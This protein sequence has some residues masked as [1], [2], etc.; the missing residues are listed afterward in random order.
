MIDLDRLRVFSEV[1]R[2]G[3]VTAAAKALHVT[4]SAVSQSLAKLEDQLGVPLFV[5]RH[6]R[7]VPTAAAATLDEIVAPFL[8]RLEHGLE[9]IGRAHHE[10]WG[11]IRLGAPA[12][13]G[14]HRLPALLAA[15]RRDHPGVSFELTLGHPSA[16][17]PRLD[18]GGLDLA[19]TDVFETGP[20]HATP[21]LEVV[22]VLEERLVLCGS[23][24][25]EAEHLGGSR[26]FGRLSKASFV[27]YQP[28]APAIRGWFVH[29]FDREPGRVEIALAVESVQAV[30]AAVRHGM[31][32][33]VVPAHTICDEVRDG[34]LVVLST[35]RRAIGNCVSLARVLDR[36]PSRAERAFVRFLVQQPPARSP[37]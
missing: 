6:R 37:S 14:A 27:A 33:G 22:E 4:P 16:L 25:Y 31:G 7:L 5:R 35:R 1:H 19:F 29:H 26:G 36:V 12:E 24:A 15:F 21:G 23:P 13:F 17:L 11:V 20:R 18:D 28:R 3:S 8:A 34:A 30:I 10:L 2:A 32:L 9:Q